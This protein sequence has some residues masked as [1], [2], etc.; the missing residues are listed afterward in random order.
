MPIS[1]SIGDEMNL[2]V[3]EEVQINF[4]TEPKLLDLFKFA[5]VQMKPHDFVLSLMV[6]GEF[7]PLLAVFATNICL[8]T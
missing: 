7:K 8:L 5:H 3:F 6:T 4:I 1:S 2:S